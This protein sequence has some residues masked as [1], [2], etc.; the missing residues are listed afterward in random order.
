MMLYAREEL[1][2]ARAYSQGGLSASDL[3][4]AA[5]R[6]VN[7]LEKVQ[8]VDALFHRVDAARGRIEALSARPG[9]IARLA[10][11]PDDIEVKASNFLEAIAESRAID[12]SSL[13]SATLV[14]AP[15]IGAIQNG[16]EQIN[17]SVVEGVTKS[18]DIWGSSN[19]IEYSS[20]LY[21]TPSECSGLFSVLVRLAFAGW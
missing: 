12:R 9:D 21:N 3:M 6:V 14:D 7:A 1:F 11:S 2:A 20:F 16:S 17:Q 18:S 15:S 8:S 13:E 10:S 4:L 5:L 19:Q